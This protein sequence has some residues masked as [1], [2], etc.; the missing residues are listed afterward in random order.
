MHNRREPIDSGVASARQSDGSRPWVRAPVG[1]PGFI[2]NVDLNRAGFTLIEV[3]L[4]I[5]VLAILAG[6]VV[7]KSGA[8]TYDQLRSAA[9][10]LAA[11]IAYTR[12]LAVTHSSTYRMAFDL[13]EN[14]YVIQH[15]GDGQAVGELPGSP[16][17]DA[18]APEGQQV[19]DLD[20]L[21][22][23]GPGV[24]IAAVA[25]YGSVVG[26][27]H[28]VE[29]DPLGATDPAGY[30]VIWL[31]AGAGN[32]QRYL[33]VKVNPVTGL[34]DVVGFSAELPPWATGSEGVGGAESFGGTGI[35]T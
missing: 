20:D 23:M 29:F 18:D 34:A 22:L 21:P 14:R 24:R 25:T 7:P 1:R 4:V 32:Q 35:G 13:E 26:P 5:S 2:G 12:S 3:L 10:I 9:R 16:F 11:D 19:V 17:G 6:I 8:G 27:I 33:T 30:T 15:T 31:A 28:S